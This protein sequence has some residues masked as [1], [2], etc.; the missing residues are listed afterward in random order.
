MEAVLQ[1]KS[2]TVRYGGVTAL[3][4]VDFVVPKGSL[5]ALMG[6]NGSGKTTLLK[7]LYGLAPLA[8][9]RVFLSE[10]PVR[11]LP[12]KLVKLG[13][14]MVPQG[15]RVF[16][17]LSVRENLELGRFVRGSEAGRLEQV[18]ELFPDLKTMLKK[19]AGKLSGGQQQMVALGRGLMSSPH[20]LLLDEPTLGLAPKVVKEVFAAIKKINTE[21]GVTV[22][23][24]EHNIRS[25]LDIADWGVV[26]D[27]GK[28]VASEAANILRKSS[29]M[30]KVFLGQME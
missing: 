10:E 30:Q 3:D 18:L 5:V 6:P 29:V 28:V 19:P 23:V 27:K 1:L 14:V 7:A 22:V 25:L 13:V 12:H 17:S 15:K 21:L 2:A 26:L 16:P 20:V 4:K 11:P 9:G 8:K 24:V